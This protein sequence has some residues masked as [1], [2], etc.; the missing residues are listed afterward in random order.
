[1]KQPHSPRPSI[2]AATRFSC[3]QS[4]RTSGS[5]QH[6]AATGLSPSRRVLVA[7]ASSAVPSLGVGLVL[8]RPSWSRFLFAAL[9][10]GLKCF[11]LV[12]VV[13]VLV[14]ARPLITAAAQ[15]V[16]VRVYRTAQI[17]LCLLSGRYHEKPPSSSLMVTLARLSN[18]ISVIG[19]RAR[20]FL[21]YSAN[22]N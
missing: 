8:V 20:F 21:V 15:A 18:S 6:P 7:R 19:T 1:R 17:Q 5:R 4:T 3:N 9:D 14:D 11:H 10:V 16:R 13:T 12:D 22:T 2:A